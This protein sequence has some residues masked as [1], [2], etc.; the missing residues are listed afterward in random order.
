MFTFPG[1][2][3]KILPAY[4]DTWTDARYPQTVHSTTNDGPTLH[5]SRGKIDQMYSVV[6]MYLLALLGRPEYLVPN[7]L[8]SSE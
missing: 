7:M 2:C 1:H 6:T 5:D 4:R 3:L 8:P